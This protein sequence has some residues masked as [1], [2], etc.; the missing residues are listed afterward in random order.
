LELEVI[1]GFELIPN[2]CEYFG[3]GRLHP[4]DEGFLHIALNLSKRIN[5][6]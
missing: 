2:M 5:L 1:N 3:D 4:K 6:E